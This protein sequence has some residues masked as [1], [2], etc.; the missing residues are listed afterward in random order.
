MKAYEIEEM[1]KSVQIL[2]EA[3]AVM[4]STKGVGDYDPT[5]EALRK[6]MVAIADTIATAAPLT[7]NPPKESAE[8]GGV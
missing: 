3:H 7:I 2:S 6:S 1:A 4:M 8:V 5:V